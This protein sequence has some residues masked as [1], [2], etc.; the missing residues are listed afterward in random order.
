MYLNFC[1]VHIMLTGLGLGL[2]L[3]TY[4]LGLRIFALVSSSKT[5][6]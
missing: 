2:G 6:A 1:F 5:Y 3:I 4:G